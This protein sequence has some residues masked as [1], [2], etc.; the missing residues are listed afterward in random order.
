MFRAIFSPHT[1]THTCMGY[2]IIS[3][4]HQAVHVLGLL[5]MMTCYHFSTY[6]YNL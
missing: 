2:S 5:N 6:M 1:H 3:T 4:L